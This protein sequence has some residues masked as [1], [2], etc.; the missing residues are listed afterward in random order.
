MCSYVPEE[1]IYAAGMLPYR[2]RATGCTRTTR[3]DAL[4]S[5]FSCSFARSCL[6]FALDGTYDFLDGLVSLDSCAQIH[7]LYDNWR[8]KARLP[9]MYLLNLPHKNSDSAI[10]WYR[11]EIAAFKQSLEKAF[12]VTVTD[13]NLVSAIEV[14][15]ETRMLLRKVYE[16]RKSENPPITGFQSQG[17]VLAAMSMPREQY[18]GLLRA[19]L[20]EI[21]SKEPIRNS[22]ARLM[23]VGS[24]LDDPAFIKIIEDQGGLVVT[25]ALCFGSRYF[26]E[27]T[28]TDGDPLLSLS[29]SY[30][31]RPKCPRMMNQH[32]SLFEFIVDMVQR[33][34][35]DGIIFQKMQFCNLW[36]GES[37]Y[38]EKKLK[39]LRI[40]FLSIEREHI[41]T[42]AAQIATRVEA[43]IEM[44]EGVI[45]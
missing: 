21:S 19:S 22:R 16:L 10:A 39:E 11:G 45:E 23:V 26:W 42:N 41:V 12:G 36:G 20:K 33:F 28:E 13:E 32:V 35:V 38:L 9:F 29:R 17:L 14:Y 18:N 24:A 3:S 4:M 1:I 5:N 43:F 7:R 2:I 8:F 40:P 30:L 6:E 27:P 15:N 25:D 34:K 31:S 37:L 44:I